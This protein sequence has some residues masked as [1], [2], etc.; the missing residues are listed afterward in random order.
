MSKYA[1]E[2]LFEYLLGELPV[3]EQREIEAQLAQDSALRDEVS[4]LRESL[5]D[6]VEALP[7]VPPPAF[8]RDDLA[9]AIEGRARFVPFTYRVADLFDVEPERAEQ[10]LL[11]LDSGEAWAEGPADNITV[12]VVDGGPRTQGSGLVGFVKLMPGALFPHHRHHGAE[13][14]LILCGAYQDSDGSIVQRGDFVELGPEVEH[15]LA[16]YGDEI[17]IGA[18][19]AENN[20]FFSA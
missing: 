5:A 8:V 18:V 4:L 17:C 2:K 14:V 12:R 16:T 11:G 10:L 19:V 7:S 20:E 1:E 6:A 9:E 13:R 15:S 3:D